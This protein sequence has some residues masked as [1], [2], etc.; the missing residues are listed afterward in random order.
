MIIYKNRQDEFQ[1][2]LS[3]ASNFKGECEG[4]YFPQNKEEVS[5]I[6]TRANQENIQL[7]VAGNRTGLTG[8]S[9][10]LAGKVIST[11]KMDKIV[12]ANFDKGEVI[13][14]PGIT[15]VELQTYLMASNYFYPPDP[16]EKNCFIGGTI[17][18]NASGARTFKYGS[19]RNFIEALEIVLANGEIFYLERRKYFAKKNEFNFVT[20]AGTHFHFSFPTIEPTT[21]KNTAGYFLKEDVDLIDL[22]IGSEGTL[23]VITEAKLKILPQPKKIVSCVAFFKTE[24]DSLNFICDARDL[25]RDHRQ[26]FIDARALEYFDGNSLRFLQK[27][28]AKIKS[29]FNSAVWFEFESENNE[30]EALEHWLELIS[31]H[32]GNEN[33]IWFALDKKDFE[34]IHEFR[35]AISAK[36]NEYVSQRGLRKLGTDTAVPDRNF[37]QFYQKS[38]SLIEKEKLKYII[39]GHAGNSHLHINL[40]PSNENE[41]ETAKKLYSEIC[42]LSVQLE[43]TVSAEHGIGKVK[44]NYLK[45]MYDESTIIAMARI[46]KCFDP[47]LILNIGNIFDDE[48]LIHVTQNER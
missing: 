48:L 33:D 25:S 24:A 35:H 31:N 4:V 38:K 43:G 45:M 14:Q 46:K 11:A 26:Q 18:T 20:Q 13:V 37:L 8:S 42:R 23:G 6:V 12:S 32:N 44:R 2:Y 28:F 9:V 1:D 16:T 5:E 47:N 3:D 36:A 19:T 22:F 17:A 21:S 27:D 40:L 15:L 30:D 29:H 10:P 7:T 34:E 41:F 39:Y